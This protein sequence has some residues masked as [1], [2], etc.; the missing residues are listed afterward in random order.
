MAVIAGGIRCVGIDMR[1]LLIALL[2]A[3][4]TP[5]T[6]TE[7]GVRYP[8][9]SIAEPAQA[10]AALREA[11]AEQTR[12]EREFAERDAD[13]HKRFLV[14]RCREQARRD[15]LLAESE[16]RRVR[17][18][19]RDLQRRLQAEEAVRKRAEAA[20]R[21]PTGRAPPPAKESR[22]PRDP[23]PRQSEPTTGGSRISPEDAARNRAAHEQR[24]ADRE[25][26]AARERAR[27]EERAESVRRYEEKQAEAARRAEKSEVERKENE[28]RRAERRRQLEEKEAQREELRRRAEESTKAVGTR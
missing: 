6:A 5:A 15:K 9:G 19:A 10:E 28:A 24:I 12:I 8:I 1:R 18:E 23:R 4:S 25:Q 20:E 26:D 16:V 2:F 7:L 11:D 21:D 13:C 22:A 14:N 27:V 17:L 3:A